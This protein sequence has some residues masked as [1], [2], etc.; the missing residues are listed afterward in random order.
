MDRARPKMLFE[1]LQLAQNITFRRAS[2]NSQ[3]SSNAFELNY[4]DDL[5]KEKQNLTCLSNIFP[6][7]ELKLR[8][9]KPSTKL[10]CSIFLSKYS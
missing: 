7:R 8:S 1:S 9:A 10:F 6:K 4:F 5:F 3:H 2:Q